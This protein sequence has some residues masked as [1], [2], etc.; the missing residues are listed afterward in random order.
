MAV[1]LAR[2]VGA[3]A[4]LF[5]WCLWLVPGWDGSL[6]AAGS[7]AAAIGG[8]ALVYGAAALTLRAPEL[9]ALVG[10]VRRRGQTL[11]GPLGG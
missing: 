3:S 8:G 2:T 9:T 4:V 1:S 6:R 5:L 7:T 10:M 11:P